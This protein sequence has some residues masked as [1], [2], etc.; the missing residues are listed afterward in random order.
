MQTGSLRGTLSGKE[1]IT[2]ARFSPDSQYVVTMDEGCDVTVWRTKDQQLVFVRSA[3][4]A[5]SCP[6]PGLPFSFTADGN[7]L[8]TSTGQGEL[9]VLRL[10]D[11]QEEQRAR[12]H[13]KVIFD[14][15][16]SPDGR[17]VASASKDRGLV[18]YDLQARGA[19]FVYMAN[20]EVDRARFSPDGQR[21]LATF[22]DRTVQLFSV[23]SGRPLLEQTTDDNAAATFSP[24][25]HWLLVTD[26]KHRIR[27]FPVSSAAILKCACNV[28]A[29]SG[30]S[31]NTIPRCAPDSARP[32]E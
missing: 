23:A 15:T 5:T 3:G 12:V 29:A 14:I 26:R 24:D 6:Y 7:K 31:V 32:A 8:L 2:S 18:L 20:T 17:L 11:G 25:G 27:L 19:R 10:N 22:G 21:L 9:V 28:V 4:I 16:A 1:R 13:G 30:G